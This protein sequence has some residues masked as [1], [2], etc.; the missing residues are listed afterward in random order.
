[1]VRK[2]RAGRAGAQFL[3]VLSASQ[4]HVHLASFQDLC[5]GVGDPDLGSYGTSVGSSWL[6]S[7]LSGTRGPRRVA[8]IQ[9]GMGR[10]LP[11]ALYP[12]Q[13]LADQLR[14]IC[15]LFC[16]L[17]EDRDHVCPMHLSGN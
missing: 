16:P 6:D 4:L 12:W 1:M 11:S 9:P 2:G 17:H 8:G 15:A 14:H 5:H 7:A 3:G 13:H 10:P